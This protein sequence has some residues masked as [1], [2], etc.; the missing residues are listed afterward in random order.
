MTAT[1][2]VQYLGGAITPDLAE[3]LT[4]AA[5]EQFEHEC[6]RLH[7][8]FQAAQ[9]GRVETHDGTGLTELWLDYPVAVL[10]A[11]KIGQNPAAPDE[12][13]AVADPDVIRIDPQVP[14]RILRTDGGTFGDRADQAS[15]QITYD[16]AEDLPPLARAAVMLYAAALS[17]NSGSEGIKSERLGGYSVDYGTLDGTQIPGWRA[18]VEAHRT[19][20]L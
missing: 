3:T 19:V 6:G 4:L 8:P 20:L 15:I 10:T 14:N 17:R 5:E 11:V 7:R 13:L 16:A 12:S 2:L 9:P 18:A 1:E